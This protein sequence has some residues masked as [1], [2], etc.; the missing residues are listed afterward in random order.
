MEPT[1][2][3][4]KR[5][6]SGYTV[7]PSTALT[8]DSHDRLGDRRLGSEESKSVESSLYYNWSH[9]YHYAPFDGSYFHGRNML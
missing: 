1:L 6:P 2:D 3:I 9:L 7:Y 4:D 8:H 5:W